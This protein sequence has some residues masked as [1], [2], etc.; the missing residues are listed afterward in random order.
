M[1]ARTYIDT[2]HAYI[3]GGRFTDKIS[4]LHTILARSDLRPITK[5]PAFVPTKMAFTPSAK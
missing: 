3:F 5:V 2:G 1:K 4:A